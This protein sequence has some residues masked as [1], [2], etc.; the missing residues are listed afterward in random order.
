VIFPR[1]RHPGKL[2]E[3]L[4]RSPQAPPAT[5]QKERIPMKEE[6]YQEQRLKVKRIPLKKERIQEERP[7]VE[8]SQV[9]EVRV[10]VKI[11]HRR[12]GPPLKLLPAG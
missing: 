5:L 2:T 12:K 11:P 3:E 7:K 1:S 8:R 4:L 9:K 10:K 6:R